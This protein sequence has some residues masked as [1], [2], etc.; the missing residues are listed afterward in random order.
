MTRFFTSLLLLVSV[1]ILGAD[2]PDNGIYLRIR[3]ET[4][5]SVMSQDGQKIYLGKKQE[6]TILKSELLS[7]NNANDSF[8]LELTL[9][10]D[11]NLKPDSYI[12]I[13]AGAAYAQSE[14]AELY[15]KEMSLIRFRFSGNEN[16]K[17]VSEYLKTPVVYRMHPQYSLRVLFIPSKQ[18]FNIGEEVTATLQI[19]NVGTKILAFRKGG[20]NRAARDNQYIFSAYLNSR[21]VKDIGSSFDFGG[22]SGS[23]VL[24]PGGVFEDKISLSKWFAFDKAGIYVIHGSYY[25]AF[26]DPGAKSCKTIWEDYVSADFTVHIIE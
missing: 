21:Q 11:E 19:A 13:V 16:A 14:S 15:N 2:Q 25:L 12:V 26:T 4:A 1:A 10:Y 22:A 9:P 8:L 20:R 3:E 18:K 24:K 17:Q 7:E 23:R 5:Q 6:L